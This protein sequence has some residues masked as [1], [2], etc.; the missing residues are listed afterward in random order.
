M[1]KSLTLFFPSLLVVL[2]TGGLFAIH[3]LYPFGTKTI[4]WCDMKQQVL[5]LTIQLGEMLKDG[6][7]FYSTLNAGGMNFWGVFFYYLASPFSLLTLLVPASAMAQFMN[8]LVVLRLMAA[9][10]TARLYFA[11]RN[12][13][14]HPG[15]STA[16]SLMY[17]F[18]GYGM[19][20]YQNITWLDLMILFPLLLLS[21][22]HLVEQGGIFPYIAALTAS[23]ILQYYISYCVV[24]FTILFFSCWL[25]LHGRKNGTGVRFLTGSA[26]AAL[27]SAPVWLPS[28]LQ[29]LSSG[30]TRSLTDSLQSGEMFQWLTTKVPLLLCTAVVLPALLLLL[31]KR[32]NRSLRLHTMLLGLMLVPVFAEPINKMW[33]TG[34]YMAFP[35]RYGFITVMMGLA[36]AGLLLEH[37]VTLPERSAPRSLAL[38]IPATILTASGALAFWY[39]YPNVISRYARTLWGNEDSFLLLLAAFML[40][41]LGYAIL[42]RVR[43]HLTARIFSVL[44]VGLVL[45]ES[46]FNLEVY[47][48]STRDTLSVAQW[49]Q[50]ADL[51]NRIEDD[52]FFR[53]KADQKDFD[54]TMMG[55][56]G[57]N[58]FGHYTSLTPQN[59]IYTMKQ[60]G[61]SSYWME[62]GSHGG[63]AFT[64]SLLSIGY[65]ISQDPGENVVYENQSYTITK[66]EHTLGLG[67][68]TTAQLPEELPSLS[69]LGLQQWLFETLFQTDEPLF[70][71]WTPAASWQNCTDQGAENAHQIRIT[72]ESPTISW[73]I[74]VGESRTL[75][76]DCFDQCT[77][78]LTE[79][80]YDSFQVLVNGTE[81]AA[82]YPTQSENGLL[83]LGQFE[84]E[85]VTVTVVSL[86][87]VD[88]RS[89]GLW[90]MDDDLWAR[91]AETIPQAGLTQQRSSFS[92][93]VETTE[94]ANCFISL[95]QNAG[96]T[97]R[98]NGKKVEIQPVLGCFFSIPLEAG[99]NQIEISFYPPGLPAGLVLGVAGVIAL[100]LL[101]KKAALRRRMETALEPA[102]RVITCGMGILVIGTVYLFPIICWLAGQ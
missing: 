31:P 29:F 96:C 48:I 77:T 41:V 79:P 53:V 88:C 24:L 70:T 7:L 99:Q 17:A 64:D 8:I 49:Q 85:T 54:V 81:I 61:Y 28:F 86:K 19:L 36:T 58:T 47:V 92:G 32:W 26:V 30:R 52:S 97:V 42:I 50:V 62:L 65:L 55:A 72:G 38:A 89:F 100:L 68:L 51:G 90:A 91:T 5:P 63:T 87:N 11:R 10:F 44:L 18:C 60:L 25:L 27:L 39:F 73:E 12:P 43:S 93:T 83:K 69:R 80:I 33:H 16:L 59:T 23:V 75:Y 57:Y 21:F 14:L 20:F 98:V 101:W 35:V 45:A 56:M 84:N 22:W 2:L 13:R 9:A 15:I 66:L 95:P 3:G 74:P 1:K 82:S 46:A 78:N 67:L 94:A 4:V 34:N 102:A 37:P 76:F 6:S 40:L 71:D